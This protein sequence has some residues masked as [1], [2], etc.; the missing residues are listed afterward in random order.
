MESALLFCEKVGC[1]LDFVVGGQPDSHLRRD[2][3]DSIG[4]VGVGGKAETDGSCVGL[5]QRSEELRKASV[6]PQLNTGQDSG[7][8]RVKRTQMTSR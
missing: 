4:I 5:D 1:G 2:R 7:G 3:G 8:H 6:F